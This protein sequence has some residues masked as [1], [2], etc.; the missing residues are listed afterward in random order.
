M[1]AIFKRIYPKLPA[2][3][4]IFQ[5]KTVID[6]LYGDEINE[7]MDDDEIVTLVVDILKWDPPPSS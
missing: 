2:K 3:F 4:T 1:E 5:I 6:E 7:D